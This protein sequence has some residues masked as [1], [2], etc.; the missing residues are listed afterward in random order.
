MC[1]CQRTD[2]IFTYLKPFI[3]IRRL[4][5][6][7]YCDCRLCVYYVVSPFCS[8]AFGLY[9]FCSKFSAFLISVWVFFGEDRERR[10]IIL[11][12]NC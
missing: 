1:L 4:G 7:I 12:G 8:I 6:E 5:L 2:I 11:H 3:Y 9:L 10:G